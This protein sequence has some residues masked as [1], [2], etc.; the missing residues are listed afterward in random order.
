VN[1][2]LEETHEDSCSSQSKV[3]DTKD[4]LPAGA[5]FFERFN[6]TL[7]EVITQSNLPTLNAA[8]F[9][10][11]A[12][13]REVRRLY[14]E[15][16]NDRLAICMA[17]GAYYRFIDLFQKPLAECLHTPIVDLISA[18]E[19]LENNSVSPI[20]QPIR[21]RGRSHSSSARETL[22]GLVAATVRRLQEANLSAKDAHQAVARQLNQLGLRPERG[23]GRISEHTVKNWCN[24]VSGDVGRHGVASLMYG[25]AFT[26][27]ECE[28]FAAKAKQMG[29]KPAALHTLAW[30]IGEHFRAL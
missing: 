28:R 26:E 30:W 5:D 22:R 21:H 16:E 10:L 8:L 2:A 25:Q 9:L 1:K 3:D 20:V 6:G 24:E 12:R 4:P 7:P 11:F 29:M 27:S 23:S 14:H 18:L 13:L 17:L 19:G 15:T